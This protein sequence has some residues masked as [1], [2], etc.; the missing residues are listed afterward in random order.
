MLTKSG[1]DEHE[2][3]FGYVLSFPV[4][5]MYCLVKVIIISIAADIVTKA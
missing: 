4:L 1:K 5:S 3:D 2:Q